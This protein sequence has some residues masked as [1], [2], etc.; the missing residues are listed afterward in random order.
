MPSACREFC[1]RN[2]IER[3]V[4][5][6]L[7]LAKKHFSFL[8]QPSFEVVDDPESRENYLAIH[9]GVSGEP[10]QVFLRSETFL[11]DFVTS[12]DSSKQPLINLV[13]HAI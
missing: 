6:T 10:H 8:G 1:A 12:I 9:V 2:R 4:V 13:Y 11:D 5:Q 7:D 3:E